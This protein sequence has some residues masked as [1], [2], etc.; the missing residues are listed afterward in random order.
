MSESSHKKA[1]LSYYKNPPD[2]EKPG[3]FGRGLTRAYKR[4]ADIIRS[5]ILP[6]AREPK[7][8]EVGAGSGLMTYF[9]TQDFQGEYTALDISRE[10][11]KV[12]EERVES[13][14]VRYVCGDGES[15]DFPEQYFDAVVGADIIHH[16]E[17][18]VAAF[19]RWKR[20]VRPGGKMCFLE[21][22]IYN[23]LNLANIGDE[24]EVRSFLNTDTN[25]AKWSRAA[26]W[27]NVSVTPAPAFT[28]PHPEI[29]GPVYDAVDKLFVRIPVLNKLTAL[30]LIENT[31]S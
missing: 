12:A 1:Q 7:I 30:W 27:E 3:F 21:T 24:H 11:L 6:L 23:P 17:S 31:R 10:M 18:P 25:L 5:V 13:A 26:G 22:N 2:Y 19:S 8:L 20:L 15:P 4:K 14:D 28:P 9:L 29:L 16:L